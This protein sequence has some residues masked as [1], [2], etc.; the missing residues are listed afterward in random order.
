MMCIPCGHNV[1]E[2]C[3]N[4]WLQNHQSTCPECRAVVD[5]TVLNRDLLNLIESNNE[6]IEYDISNTHFSEISNTKCQENEVLIDKTLYSINL[7]DNSASM[8][9]YDDGK[10]FHNDNDND[11]ITKIDFVSRWDEAVFK[12]LLI[13]KYNIKRKMKSSYYLLNPTTQRVNSLNDWIEN[14]DYITIDPEK[15]D[16]DEKL[17]ILQNNILKY[18]NIRRDTPL[19]RMTHYIVQYL[20]NLQLLSNIPI[21]YNI[22]TDGEPNNK[23]Q[24]E[25]YL[26]NLAKENNI[27]LTI[28]LCTDD[29]DIV[30][31]YND[32]D[33]NLGSEMSGIDVLD[34]FESEQNEIINV[35]NNFI[36]YTYELHT[37]RMAGL[38]SIASDLL[39]EELL[40]PNYAYKICK[41]LLKT[42][43]IPHWSKRIEY[44]NFI[45]RNNKKVYNY[46]KK[47]MT[48]LI[49]ID[50]L[51]SLNRSYRNKE[52]ISNILYR[53][54][55][56]LIGAGFILGFLLRN[57]LLI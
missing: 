47:C 11:I 1:C 16:T 38:N 36:T 34:D 44:L 29:E 25:Y 19:D 24:F 48:D 55:Y 27:F 56:Y 33:K 42:Q 23:S 21:C 39:D 51:D 6:N 43:D 32:L 40:K 12:T 52:I 8:G 31:Y 46:K 37:A 53:N 57:I 18:T 49:N 50:E 4:H 22:I 20:K 28:N 13:A 17:A 35:G 10:I 54:K 7:I 9:N 45:K 14:I 30:D 41:E 15:D 26:K 5:N 2:P 3:I